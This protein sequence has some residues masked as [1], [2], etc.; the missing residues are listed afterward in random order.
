M[1]F[2]NHHHT[3][4]DIKKKVTIAFLYCGKKVIV[5]S[6]PTLLDASIQLRRFTNKVPYILDLTTFLRDHEEV[7][8]AYM[9]AKRGFFPLN[10]LL[11]IPWG[12]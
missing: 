1:K 11:R 2:H 7:F 10:S 9:V 3:S 8:L 4:V 5:D 6:T 12:K